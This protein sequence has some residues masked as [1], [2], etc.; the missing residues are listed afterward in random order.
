MDPFI[1]SNNNFLGNGVIMA[2][3][4]NLQKKMYEMIL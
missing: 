4:F 1:Y 2:N 3:R